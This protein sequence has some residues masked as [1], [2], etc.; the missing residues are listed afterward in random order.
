MGMEFQITEGQTAAPLVSKEE[1]RQRL[2]VTWANSALDAEIVGLATSAEKKFEIDTGRMIA[3]REV[4]ATCSRPYGPYLEIPVSPAKAVTAVSYKDTSGDLREWPAE[5]WH[6]D[7]RFALPRLRPK[8][9]MGWPDVMCCT[10]DAFSVEL[11]VGYEEDESEYE[12]SRTAVLMLVQHWFDNNIVSTLHVN[13]VPMA[14][15]TI[16]WNLKLPML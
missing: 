6:V 16:V 10:P 4:V 15:E 14:Y 8:P 9:G 12:L 1:A 5:N 2:G 13:T 3:Q 7:Y 11:I